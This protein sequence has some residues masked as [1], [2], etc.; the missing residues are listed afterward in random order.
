MYCFVVRAKLI[1]NSV[2]ITLNVTF[3]GFLR[4][5]TSVNVGLRVPGKDDSGYSTTI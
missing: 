4:N 1:P 3:K 2:S 5:G